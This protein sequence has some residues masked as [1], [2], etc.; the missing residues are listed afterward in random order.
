MTAALN[1]EAILADAHAQVDVIDP[2]AAQLRKNLERL[3]A[4]INANAMIS[5]EFLAVIHQEFVERTLHRLGG[6]KWMGDH[7]EIG[8]EVIDSPV[9]LTGLPR[10]GTTAFQYLFDRDQRYRSI[11]TWEAESPLP[12]PGFDPESAA[13][14]SG[15]EGSILDARLPEGFETLHLI[16]LDGPQECHHFL[17]QGYAAAG[18]HNLMNVPD[19]FDFL[20]DDLDFTAAYR[21]HKRQLQLLQWRMPR[22]PWALKY[23]NHVLAMDEVLQVYPNARF[24]MTHRDPAQIVASIAKLTCELRGLRAHVPPDPH[25]VGRQMV[26]F[27]QRHIDRIMQ[28]T[29]GP[30]ADRVV[31]VDYYRMLNEPTA[32][33]EA[34]HTGLGIDSPQDVRAAMAEWH[35]DNPKGARG[36]NPYALEQFGLNGDAVAEQFSDYMRRFDIPRETAGLAVMR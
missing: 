16:D 24:V 30:D 28:F 31:H 5:D 22:R 18:Y 32:V 2:E 9:F 19:Y 20:V 29:G 21:I 4:S 15:E 34:V 33:M 7:P 17:E 36:A 10:S 13:R 6:L 11:R 25:E 14:R 12:P 8:E 26:H 27:I 35:R 23:P 3:V 1:A